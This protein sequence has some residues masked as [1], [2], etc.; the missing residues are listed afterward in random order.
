MIDV[1]MP[2]GLSTRKML[3]ESLKHNVLSAYSAEEGIELATRNDVDL[4]MLDPKLNDVTCREVS[5][6]IHEIKPHVPVLV[7]APTPYTECDGADV[8]ISSF[9]PADLVDYL[10]E[11]SRKLGKVPMP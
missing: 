11:L 9:S 6:R 3:I 7:V 8:T 5:R 4:V 1:E 2:E 10:R